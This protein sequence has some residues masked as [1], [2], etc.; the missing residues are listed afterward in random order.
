MKIRRREMFILGLELSFLAVIVANSEP[1]KLFGCSL[2]VLYL[3]VAVSNLAR[4][5]TSLMTKRNCGSYIAFI[6]GIAG[7]LGALFVPE[8]P[9]WLALVLPL[10][11]IG[12]VIGILG[13]PNIVRALIYFSHEPNKEVSSLNC[14]D[15]PLQKHPIVRSFLSMVAF[16]L[17]LLSLFPF[18]GALAV[19]TGVWALVD[20][21]KHPRKH[22]CA[23]AW[24]GV[25]AGGLS[26]VAWLVFFCALSAS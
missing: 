12:F 10:C 7:C 8:I 18:V 26:L 13:I 14:D 2:L 19:T 5:L 4:M 15:L 1:R 3:L 6:G 24:F 17:G 25:V 9:N 23:R 22:G 11:D 21:K 20:I 16:Y